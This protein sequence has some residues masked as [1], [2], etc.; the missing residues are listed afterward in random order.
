M[1]LPLLTNIFII[2]VSV[3]SIASCAIGIQ[4]MGDVSKGTDAQ[5]RNKNFLIVMLVMSIL[6]LLL[7]G[8]LIYS[9]M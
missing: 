9:S 5:K 1:P 8:F 7:G 6:A 4:A 2:A 3:L